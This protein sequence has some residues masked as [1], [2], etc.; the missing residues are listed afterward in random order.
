MTE[1]TG[2]EPS[3]AVPR[4]FDSV[5]VDAFA[6]PA[7]DRP[8]NFCHQ[9]SFTASGHV[10]AWLVYDRWKRGEKYDISVFDPWR[11]FIHSDFHGSKTEKLSPDSSA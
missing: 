1:Q 5:V 8:T 9:D 6:V 10:D 11:A 2:V 7:L 4:F 3:G